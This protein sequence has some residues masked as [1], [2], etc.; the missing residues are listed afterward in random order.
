M[1]K[2]NL[3]IFLMI[4]HI[5]TTQNVFGQVNTY[6]FKNLCTIKVKSSPKKHI[7]I[8]VINTSEDSIYVTPLV[9][10]PFKKPFSR[11]SCDTIDLVTYMITCNNC[12]NDVTRYS[13]M[14]GLCRLY[15]DQ[16]KKK[17]KGLLSMHYDKSSFK[18]FVF[19]V[20]SDHLKRGVK[21]FIPINISYSDSVIFSFEINKLDD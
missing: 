12:N 8:K 7:K 17:G 11:F 14:R 3:L 10:I 15:T 18:M 9:N 2:A 16:L 5:I 6:T 21:L 19:R 4:Y 20:Y 13:S 1:K